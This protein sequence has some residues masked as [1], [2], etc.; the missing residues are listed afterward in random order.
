MWIE[1]APAFLDKLG[2]AAL[3][4]KLSKVL[5]VF[6]ALGVLLPTMHQSSLGS[7]L[8]VFGYQVHPLWQSGWV[9]P[10]MY[11]ITA[12][13]L[14]FSAVF[15]SPRCRRWAFER[16]LETPVDGPLCDDPLGHPCRLPGAASRSSRIG[17]ALGHAFG[18]TCRRSG[19][20]S[21]WPCSSRPL[22]A[23]QPGRAPRS[24]HAVSRRGAMMP[25][26][27]FYRVNCFLIGYDDGRGLELFP[28]DGGDPGHLGLFALRARPTSSSSEYSRCCPRGPAREQR[29]HGDRQGTRITIDPITRIEG[30]LR[31]DCE[32]E[33]GKVAKAWSSGQMWR[34][35]ELILH[36]RDPRDAWIFTQ[37]I[38][39]V[40]T[41]VHAIVS[42]RA[43]EN[44]LQPG[45]A[46]ERRST[47]AT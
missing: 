18:P 13:M 10:L 7:L 4:K 5:F 2:L 34:G 25:G 44:A 19:S 40:C 24:R 29:N 22:P 21:R 37:R 39:G 11:L 8:I 26:G 45:S 17:R 9:L 35:I 46:A 14:G 15:S 3:K 42:V 6:I 47:S 41:T 38:C 20:G 31:I 30:H 1:F 27:I 12:I 32:V 43:V 36:G 28:V 23:G 16:R 33:N